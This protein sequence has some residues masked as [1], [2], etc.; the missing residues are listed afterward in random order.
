MPSSPSHITFPEFTLTERLQ[1][2]IKEVKEHNLSIR[3]AAQKYDLTKSMVERRVK[4]PNMQ[5]KSITKLNIN[6]YL[7]V[8]EEIALKQI[9]L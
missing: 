6:G 2:A 7:N 1:Q 3:N 8:Q 9:C 5:S 4:T